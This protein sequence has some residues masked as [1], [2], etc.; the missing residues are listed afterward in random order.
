MLSRR[1][2]I[3][4]LATAALGSAARADAPMFFA[5]DGIAVRGFDTVAFFRNGAPLRGTPDIS[6]MWKNAVWHFANHE[7]REAFEA[8]PRAFAPRFGGYCAYAVG[9][10]YL[11]E[12]DPQTWQIVDGR[13]YLVHSPEVAS[14]WAQDIPGNIARANA[15]WPGVLK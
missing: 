15:N 8:N 9:R 7:N 11:T 2:F 3:S 5:P 4:G 1:L 12:T 10:G 6:V 13:L 14:L